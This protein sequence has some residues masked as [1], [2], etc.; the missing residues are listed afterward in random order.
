MMTTGFIT[1]STDCDRTYTAVLPLLALVLMASWWL[2]VTFEIL[3][4]L[5][6]TPPVGVD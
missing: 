3:T 5:S 1:L 6:F 2:I 4:P